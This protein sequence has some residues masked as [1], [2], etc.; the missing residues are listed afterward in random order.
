MGW[1]ANTGEACY[2]EDIWKDERWL[3]TDWV[4][5]EGI[6]TY[7]GLPLKSEGKVLGV[8]NFLT[9]GIR[10]FRED[11]FELASAFANGASVALH[12]ARLHDEEKT[13]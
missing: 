6:R 13:E 11:E 1:T 10:K 12:N 4:R 3:E 5:E 2:I 8:L 7:L 9:V